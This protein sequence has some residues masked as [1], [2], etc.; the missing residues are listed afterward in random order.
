[1]AISY[2]V[3][4]IS[5]GDGETVLLGIFALGMVVFGMLVIPASWV[6]E[7]RRKAINRTMTGLVYSAFGF[8]LIPLASLVWTVITLG[9]ARFNGE[10]FGSSMRNVVG[11]GGGALHAIIA[12]CGNHVIAALI[13]IAIGS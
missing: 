1:M 12:H 2:F 10:F 4:A 9:L 13:S 11:E 8:A 3:A 7:G 5:R 6:V